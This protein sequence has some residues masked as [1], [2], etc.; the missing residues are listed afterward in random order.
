VI[1]AG[2]TWLADNRVPDPPETVLLWGDARLGN[3]IFE[4]DGTPVALLD[5]E[6]TYVG[7]AD[8]DVAWWLF[9][10]EHFTTGIGLPAP[11]GFPDRQEFVAMYERFSTRPVSHLHYY[12]VLAAVRVAILMQRAASLMILSGQI[13]PSST[14]ATIN[15]VTQML[16]AL[17]GLPSLDGTASSFIGNR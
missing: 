7:S 8:S 14:M 13:P 11:E 9:M 10:F 16:A 4:P 5:W 17:L 6:M 15:P 12:E 1:S 3:T 2:L